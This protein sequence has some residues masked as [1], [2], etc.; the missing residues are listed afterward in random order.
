[1]ERYP[2]FMDWKNIVKMS[3]LSKAIYRLNAIPVKIPMRLSTELEQVLKK[4]V[5]KHRQPEKPKQSLKR[6]KLA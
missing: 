3:I 1:M 6:K 5:W 4:Y 2:V